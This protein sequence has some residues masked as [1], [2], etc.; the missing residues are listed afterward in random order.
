MSQADV[1]VIVTLHDDASKNLLRQ[2]A[3]INA[4]TGKIDTSAAQAGSALERMGA[5]SK[6]GGAALKGMSSELNNISNK[7]LTVGERLNTGFKSALGTAKQIGT[8]LSQGVAGWE[9]MKAVGGS[10]I[11]PTVDYE[12]QLA[13]M[14]NIA[15]AGK[16]TTEKKAGMEEMHAAIKKATGLY[17]GTREQGA[18][19]L[20]TVYGRMS[21]KDDGVRARAHASGVSADVQARSDAAAIYDASMRAAGATGGSPEEFAQALTAAVQQKFIKPSEANLAADMMIRSATDG[22]FEAK[23]IARHIGGQMG[24]AGMSGLNGI[25]GFK[26]LLAMNQGAI[27]GAGSGDEAANNV[28]NVL[29]KLNSVDTKKDFKKNFGIDLEREYLKGAEKGKDS[30]T[31]AVDLL[32]GEM[33]KNKDYVKAQGQ[34]KTAQAQGDKAGEA[35]AYKSMENIAAGST[36]GK[37]FQDIQ[38]LGALIPLLSSEYSNNIYKGL[39][40]S[41]G[42][43]DQNLDL[44]RGTTAFKMQQGSNTDANLKYET[45]SGAIGTV[46][47]GANDAFSKMGAEFPAL[48]GALVS[49]KDATMLAASVYGAVSLTGMLGKGGGLLGKVGVGGAGGLLSSSA[50]TA[51][52]L[53]KAGGMAKSAGV[54]GAAGT[55]LWNAGGNAMT[56]MDDK[57]GAR[58]KAEA[59]GGLVGA[60]YG[61]VV[62]GVIGSVVPVLGTALGAAAGAWLGGMAGA[63][64]GGKNSDS[65]PATPA[66][67]APPPIQGGDSAQALIQSNAQLQQV[68]AQIAQLNQISNN[69]PLEAQMTAVAGNVAALN[70]KSW[71]VTATIPVYVNGEMVSQTV[72]NINANG[73]A[74]GA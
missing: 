47:G 26:R 50:G 44:V 13:N 46:V 72:N 9:T 8:A 55:A 2:L 32:R 58:E 16:S 21:E 11:K 42:L 74:R 14:A 65:P 4:E 12:A 28:K 25:D 34:L 59:K 73:A 62:G 1:K 31:V 60:A 3:L 37:A 52:W 10:I 54:V 53:S 51:G 5:S 45:Q 70:A 40:G 17:G 19:A 29:S 63:W 38:A 36:I 27:V 33:S 64:V 61:T 30:L 35:A 6:Q 56:M 15:Y 69:A 24:V 67:A 49:L 66:M 57:A 39:D 48:T 22:G 20:N 7:A 71:T 23:D 43:G 68:N 41:A 18:A